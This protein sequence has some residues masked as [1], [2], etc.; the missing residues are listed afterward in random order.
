VH[1]CAAGL[2]QRGV[3]AEVR[4]RGGGGFSPDGLHLY[5]REI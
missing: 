4:R 3:R 5:C 2:R 1:R